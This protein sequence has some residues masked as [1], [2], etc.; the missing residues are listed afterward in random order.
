[1]K[2]YLMCIKEIESIIFDK[3]KTNA[4]LT[5]STNKATTDNM[6]PKQNIYKYCHP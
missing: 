2:E 6:S 5:I 4:A 1:M 3:H